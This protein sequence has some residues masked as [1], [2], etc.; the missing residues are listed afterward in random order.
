MMDPG[1]LTDRARMELH[2]AAADI[3]MRQR[4]IRNLG[5]Q[6]V[7]AVLIVAAMLGLLAILTLATGTF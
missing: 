4:D 5:S 7:A 2:D 6:V 1:N 3:E